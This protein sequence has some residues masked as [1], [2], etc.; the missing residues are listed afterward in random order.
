[1]E[2]FE[3]IGYGEAKSKKDAQGTAA[4]SFC[5]FLVER[6][7]ISGASLPAPLDSVTTESVSSLS[8]R[9]LT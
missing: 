4:V 7:I 6:G 3:F 9:V 8:V 1:M 2:G 5:N